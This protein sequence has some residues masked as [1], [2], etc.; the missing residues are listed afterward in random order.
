MDM[1]NER[2]DVGRRDEILNCGRMDKNGNLSH[3]KT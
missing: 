3:R 2:Q 1:E